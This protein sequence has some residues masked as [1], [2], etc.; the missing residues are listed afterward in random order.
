VVAGHGGLFAAPKVPGMSDEGWRPGVNYL[1]LPLA[2]QAMAE[3][4]AEQLAADDEGRLNSVRR[5][6]FEHAN[7]AC[8]YDARVRELLQH[9]GLRRQCS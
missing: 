9:L 6:G 7:G 3:S 2:P 5:A 8:T 4:L 1:E